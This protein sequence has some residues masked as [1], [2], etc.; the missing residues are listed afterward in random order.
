MPKLDTL[1]RR[2]NRSASLWLRCPARTVSIPYRRPT[3]EDVLAEVESR[4]LVRDQVPYLGQM[5]EAD[6]AHLSR[7]GL[8]DPNSL[9]SKAS[10]ALSLGILRPSQ[11]PFWSDGGG[12]LG[13][14]GGDDESPPDV[15]AL[16]E[17]TAQYAESHGKLAEGREIREGLLDLYQLPPQVEVEDVLLRLGSASDRLKYL[18]RLRGRMDDFENAVHRLPKAEDAIGEDYLDLVRLVLAESKASRRE[19][20]VKRDR[21]SQSGSD[22]RKGS[23]RIETPLPEPGDDGTRREYKAVSSFSQRGI[24]KGRRYSLWPGDTLVRAG[25]V[26]LVEE[27]APV[28]DDGGNEAV[29]AVPDATEIDGGFARLDTLDANLL[30]A[31]RK[32][33]LFTSEGWDSHT[34][35]DPEEMKRGL[36]GETEGAG[37]LIL[38]QVDGDA[39]SGGTIAGR[40]SALEAAVLRYRRMDLI[41]RWSGYRP[42]KKVLEDLGELLDV[43]RAEAL[44]TSASTSGTIPTSR[45]GVSHRYHTERNAEGALALLNAVEKHPVRAWKTRNEIAK[46]AGGPGLESKSERAVVSN[47]LRMLEALG[48]DVPSAPSRS[49]GARLLAS[50]LLD[51]ADEIRRAGDYH[52]VG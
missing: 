36:L 18:M 43:A 14:I 1:L 34:I 21:A 35:G 6:E 32:Y 28:S 19:V 11:I 10:E 39:E 3:W 31:A 29:A 23:N 45:P 13:G 41:H 37:R 2:R 9:R 26:R 40:V 16:I 42:F 47:A 5:I 8:A 27:A 52:G 33:N 7:H 20:E 51:N 22:T 25:V 50:S 15:R 38:L 4:R 44:R 48:V 17:R 12:N 24:E 30:Q 49:E 46:A